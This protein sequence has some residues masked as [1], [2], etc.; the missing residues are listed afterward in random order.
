MSTPVLLRPRTPAAAP[1]AYP[2]RA[3]RRDWVIEGARV[4]W[5]EAWEATPDRDATD[6]IHDAC[7]LTSVAPVV[8]ACTGY[9]QL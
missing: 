2:G 3:P 4:R 6:H 7:S 1:L 5:L 8:H 9:E